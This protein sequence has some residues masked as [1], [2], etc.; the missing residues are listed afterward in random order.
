MKAN[1]EIKRIVEGS[2]LFK[3]EQEYVI[4]L[5]I[6]VWNR[7]WNEGK[8]TTFETLELRDF[9]FYL[10]IYLLSKLASFTNLKANE[11]LRIELNRNAKKYENPK[12]RLAMPRGRYQNVLESE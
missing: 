3:H 12:Y 9:W 6:L 8:D 11:K 4:P 7:Y 5:F 10:K 1:E 2:N